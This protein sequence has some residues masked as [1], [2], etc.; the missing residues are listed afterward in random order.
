MSDKALLK[1]WVVEALGEL[2]GQGKVLAVSQVIWRRHEGDLRAA[3]SLF[4]T[5][6]Y[7][8]RWAAQVLRD[9]GVLLEAHGRR[10]G[11]WALA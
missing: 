2:G 11:T 4:Y 3:G 7:D 9:E 1:E 10:D 8:V 5:W 6:Q